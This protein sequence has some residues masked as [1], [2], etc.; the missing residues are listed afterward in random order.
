MHLACVD[1]EETERV[2]E[3]HGRSCGG[4]SLPCAPFLPSAAP[5]T[6]AIW[7]L[8]RLC[9]CRGCTC[10]CGG[11][12]PPPIP[13]SLPA[14]GQAC[15]GG[16]RS[17]RSRLPFGEAMQSRGGLTSS[18]LPF[19]CCGRS[20]PTSVQSPQYPPPTLRHADVEY[21]ARLYT[22]TFF[23]LCVS[24]STDAT[25]PMMCAVHAAGPPPPSSHMI[26]TSHT[27][28]RIFAHTRT[29]A[30]HAPRYKLCVLTDFWSLLTLPSPALPPTIQASF[31]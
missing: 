13:S 4:R 10:L 8:S 24:S 7:V 31:L 25:A 29:P 30:L 11:A 26:P 19:V 23:S 5:T 6:L 1:M 21:S 18:P 20:M 28:T 9:L 12:T 2:R 3:G 14:V 15:V 16:K 27:H 22:L 17:L